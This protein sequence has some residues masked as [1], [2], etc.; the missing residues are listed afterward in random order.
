MS[1]QF[2][3]WFAGG[4]IAEALSG[5]GA[6]FVPD[7]TYSDSHA[8][9]LAVGQLMKWTNEE[10]TKL[11]AS[12]FERAIAILLP[13]DVVGAIRLLRSY[14]IVSNR[15]HGSLPIDLGK[16]AVMLAESVNH[17]QQVLF[18]K[19]G[20]IHLLRRV[21]DDYPEIGTVV[22]SKLDDL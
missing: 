2:Q 17:Q 14:S 7:A 5:T 12:G 9:I 13:S 4:K 10:R 22:Q 15:D 19:P 20:F 11:A 16:V 21:I 8:F 18:E 6:Y 1:S 3:T